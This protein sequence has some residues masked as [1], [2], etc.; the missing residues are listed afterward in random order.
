MTEPEEPD[1]SAAQPTVPESIREQVLRDSEEPMRK[2]SDA[3]SRIAGIDLAAEKMKAGEA[4]SRMMDLKLGAMGAMAGSGLLR[5][6][7]TEQL[8]K[9]GKQENQWKERLGAIAIPQMP[10]LTPPARPPE[11]Y[12]VDAVRD[13][14]ELLEVAGEQI[15]ALAGLANAGIHVLE[16]QEELSNKTLAESAELRQ[17]VKLGQG[18]AAKSDRTIRRLTWVIAALTLVLAA[19][20]GRDFVVSAVGSAHSLMR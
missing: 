9:I 15:Q 19:V 2:M 12:V 8:A 13:V 16:R 5:D 10:A 11:F 14:V 3:G 4:A 17:T 18:Q 7:V 1:Q 6:A 20:P